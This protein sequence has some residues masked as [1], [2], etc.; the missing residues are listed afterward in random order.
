MSG[1]CGPAAVALSSGP[2]G[3]AKTESTTEDDSGPHI[4]SV[5]DVP[6]VGSA[7]GL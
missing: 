2:L 3:H 6:S 7:A 5:L 4:V 1:F